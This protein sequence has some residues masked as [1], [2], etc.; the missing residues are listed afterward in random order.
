MLLLHDFPGRYIALANEVPGSVDGASWFSQDRAGG[1]GDPVPIGAAVCVRGWALNLSSDGPATNVV[2]M[3]DASYKY[4]ARVGGPRPDVAGLFENNALLPSGFEAIIPTGRLMPGDHEAAAFTVDPFSGRYARISQSLKFAVVADWTT[5]SKQIGSARPG[6]RGNLDEIVDDSRGVVLT[7]V[8]GSVNVPRGSRLSLRGWFCDF[9][10]ER[11]SDAYAVVDGDRAYP[12]RYGTPRSD[13]VE[14]L[15]RP[16]TP[17]VGFDVRVPTANLERGSHL[18]DVVAVS[19]DGTPVRTGVA[20]RFN[21]VGA[22][23]AWVP[24][25]EMT[26]AFLDD[27]IRVRSGKQ[28]E[29]GAPLRV[30][31]GDRLFVRGWAID[32][33]ARSLAAGVVLVVDGHTEIPALYGLP[34]PDVA[35]AYR[36]GELARSGFTAEIE[37]AELDVG[38]HAAD[39][40]VLACDGRGTFK[41]AQRFDFEVY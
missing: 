28:R 35:E 23:G 6:C 31:R 21:I 26:S 12:V 41:T 30:A 18:L 36:D 39:C 8:A 27:V 1:E 33:S 13:V 29:V 40:R 17:N 24:L 11:P 2:V 10:A 32:D 16:M 22:M 3:V 20:L 15:E 19:A 14:M 25:D 9:A 38:M 4:H 34:R 7:P 5:L 37:T